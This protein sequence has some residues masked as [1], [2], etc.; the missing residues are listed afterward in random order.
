MGGAKCCT[1]AFH[2]RECDYSFGFTFPHAHVVHR[3]SGPC[4]EH[5]VPFY[6]V[7]QCSRILRTHSSFDA[8]T[9]L[10]D[11]S[12][13]FCQI[14]AMM[15]YILLKNNKKNIFYRIGLLSFP[16]DFVPDRSETFCLLMGS[17]ALAT[18][19]IHT[20]LNS[21]SI[22]FEISEQ[23]KVDFTCLHEHHQGT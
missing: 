14:S 23:V 6:R 5:G 13:M 19:H 10:L 22:S 2:Q 17:I 4:S 3:V 7:L 21:F 12:S 16:S 15:I 20:G 18:T 8:R 9:H 1:S 11:Y